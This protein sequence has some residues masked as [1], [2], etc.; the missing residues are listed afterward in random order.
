[1]KLIRVFLLIQAIGLGAFGLLMFLKPELSIGFLEATEMSSSGFYEI[2]SIYGGTSLG[3]AALLF[4]GFLKAEMIRPALYFQLAY[5]GGYAVVRIAA[6]PLD[7]IPS[8]LFWPFIG[9]EF[10]TVFL[11]I[12]CLRYLNMRQSPDRQG[13]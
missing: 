9:L 13:I 2:R 10:A 7:G 4:A 12:Y 8:K 3:G 11:T 6:L 1:M 5:T